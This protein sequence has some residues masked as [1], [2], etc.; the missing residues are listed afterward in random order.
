MKEIAI[1]DEFFEGAVSLEKTPHGIRP[2]R[3]PYE[4]RELIF[5]VGESVMKCETCAGVR[6]RFATDAHQ[7]TLAVDPHE[8]RRIFDLTINGALI[9]SVVAESGVESVTFEHLPAGEKTVE[10]WLSNNN[11]M[12]VRGIVVEE[13]ALVAP[14]DRQRRRWVTYGSSITHCADAHS[15]SRTWPAIVARRLNL[16]LTCLGYRGNCHMEP[17]LALMIRDLPA[18][19]IS[20]KVGINIQ[21]VGTLSERT[22]RPALI[23][24]VRI[25]REKHP[26]TPLAVISPVISPPREDVPGPSG[27]SLKYVRAEVQDAVRLLTEAGDRCIRYFDG[28]ELLGAGDV[29]KGLK[30]DL[31][32]PNGDGYEMLGENFLKNV[33]GRFSLT[34]S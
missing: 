6:L 10:I 26:V 24:F 7:V 18:D 15:P 27:M 23:G 22:F 21:S 1:R 14:V 33:H 3:V 31:T 30:D 16:D 8:G 29:E 19:Y 20:L 11:P 12:V 9:D 25:I 5:P 17:M 28:L 13:G 32:H 34:D 2:W 4:T